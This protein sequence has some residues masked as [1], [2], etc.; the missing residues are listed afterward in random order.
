MPN[1]VII[2]LVKSGYRAT[3]PQ[4]PAA[5]KRR[6][7]KPLSFNLP[8]FDP[9]ER[10]TDIPKRQTKD[11]EFRIVRWRFNYHF[12]ITHLKADKFGF[13]E[14][15]SVI[16]ICELPPSKRTA[17]AINVRLVFVK[18]LNG[19]KRFHEPP[20]E[21]GGADIVRSRQL[22]FVVR[23][24]HDDGPGIIE[25]LSAGRV[26]Y[27]KIETV[28]VQSSFEQVIRC[29]LCATLEEEDLE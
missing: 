7:A 11:Y 10:R 15:M 12:G 23:L 28:P 29:E 20:T 3:R 13:S 5:R 8:K 19:E 27:I 26:P 16:L 18:W 25:A 1:P 4:D 6:E 24:P 14:Y 2:R 9:L 17:P 22:D 21:I